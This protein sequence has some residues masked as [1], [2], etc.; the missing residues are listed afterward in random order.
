[1]MTVTK[2]GTGTV[3]APHVVDALAIGM[4]TDC[5]AQR[6]PSGRSGKAC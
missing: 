1:M 3:P 4:L 6:T 2:T 5:T